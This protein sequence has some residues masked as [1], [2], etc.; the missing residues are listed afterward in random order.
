[1]DPLLAAYTAAALPA[2]LPVSPELPPEAT[3]ARQ[4]TLRKSLLRT[5]EITPDILRDLAGKRAGAVQDW[6]R[7]AGVAPERLFIVEETSEES[8][9]PSARFSVE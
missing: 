4:K 1:P 8:P 7:D 2:L 3:I 5:Y 6:L 9:T